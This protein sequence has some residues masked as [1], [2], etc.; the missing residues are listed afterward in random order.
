MASLRCRRK[1]KPLMTL[2]NTNSS[3]KEAWVTAEKSKPGIAPETAERSVYWRRGAACCG[4]QS[5]GPLER[6]S[7]SRSNSVS[8]RVRVFGVN[9]E[10]DGD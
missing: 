4:S 2:I 1:V 10:D 6:G 5:R 8:K 9:G 3:F 7:M